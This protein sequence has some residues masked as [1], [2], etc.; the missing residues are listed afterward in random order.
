M[1]HDPLSCKPTSAPGHGRV[2][3]AVRGWPLGTEWAKGLPGYRA[4]GLSSVTA[5]GVSS[6]GM[7]RIGRKARSR[8]QHTGQKMLIDPVVGSWHK[9]KGEWNS[10]HR[11]L[12]RH[13][14]RKAC[15]DVP[16]C[17]CDSVHGLPTPVRCWG[18]TVTG[19][20]CL[21]SH[22]SPLP[23]TPN[24]LSVHH[25][26]RS[27]HC[28]VWS[29]T[30]EPF[31]PLL[32]YYSFLENPTYFNAALCLTAV[33]PCRWQWLG[34]TQS[35]TIG[36]TLNL[37]SL[38]PLGLPYSWRVML[39]SLC[40]HIASCPLVCCLSLLLLDALTPSI[41]MPPSQLVAVRPAS[42]RVHTQLQP[43]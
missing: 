3:S 16:Q 39:H 43:W 13:R 18:L 12:S 27:Y 22:H 10:K 33:T 34:K 8:K 17:P 20:T 40:P 28:N 14:G 35:L 31:V 19:H 2:T 25:G 23:H 6:R 21:Y 26:A 5:S 32:L 42:F 37:W 7:P 11:H 9:G 30:W 4:P 41:P 38:T 24:L 1:L 15:T 36:Y 29:R